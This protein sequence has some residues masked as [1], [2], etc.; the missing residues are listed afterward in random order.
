MSTSA[1]TELLQ[2]YAEGQRDFSSLN[3]AGAT[4]DGHS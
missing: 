1:A 2:L 4:Y 3:L